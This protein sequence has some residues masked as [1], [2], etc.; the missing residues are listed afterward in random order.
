VPH[1]S[2][3]DGWWPEGFKGA[4]GWAFE[5]D[6]SEN[7]DAKD[8][9]AIYNILEQKV[10]PL[11]YKVDDDGVPRGWVQFMKAAIKD[12]GAAFSARR[13]VKEYSQ[14]FYQPAL[15]AAAQ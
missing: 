7:R 15:T 8:A 5:G 10:V 13:M 4:N 12:T 14:K 3:L 6:T 1:L 9:E 2:I 11:F